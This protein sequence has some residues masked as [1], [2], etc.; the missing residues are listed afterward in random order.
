MKNILFITGLF[1]ATIF[2]TNIFA[3]DKDGTAENLIAQILNTHPNIQSADMALKASGFAVEGAKWGYFP[4]PS[5]VTEQQ[6]GKR[7][8]TARLEQPIWTGGKIEATVNIAKSQQKE[9]EQTL[10]EVKYTLAERCIELIASAARFSYISK[11]HEKAL[12][13]LESYNG[14][15]KRRIDGGVS[16][17]SDKQLIETRISQTK[18]DLR[19]ALTSKQTAIEQLSILSGRKISEAEVSTDSPIAGTKEQYTDILEAAHATHPKILK[20]AAKIQTSK[21]NQDKVSSS[22]YPTLSVRGEKQ[23]DALSSGYENNG[24]KIYLTAQLTPGAGLA[25]LSQIQEAR[26]KTIEA[27]RQYEN[28]KLDIDDKIAGDYNAAIAVQ[29][30]LETAKDGIAYADKVLES[31]TRLFLAG[32]RNWLDVVNAARE[33]TQNELAFY[34]IRTAGFVYDKRLSLYKGALIK[35][36]GQI[37]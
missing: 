22:L 21:Y 3:A 32:K 36:I 12:S 11:V 19:S 27:Q 4:T 35:N 24:G 1:A 9:A 31:Y 20:A 29:Y 23:I 25:L 26:L 17:L 6:G 33:V 5:I 18:N 14:M 10:E 34:E 37:R 7:S 8:F 2:A 13:R 15:I 16:S 30:R 28:E